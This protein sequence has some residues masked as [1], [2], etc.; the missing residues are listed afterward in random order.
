MSIDEYAR[1]TYLRSHFSNMDSDNKNQ[2]YI[3]RNKDDNKK[4]IIIIVIN[5]STEG[6]RAIQ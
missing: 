1:N 4:K 3:Y 5:N 6:S 2:Q